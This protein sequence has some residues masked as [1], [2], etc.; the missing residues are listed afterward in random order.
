[1]A[2]QTNIH[3]NCFMARDD[4]LCHSMSKMHIV[5][6]GTGALRLEEFYIYD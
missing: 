3:V 4:T 6:E 5:G 2:Q 1:M